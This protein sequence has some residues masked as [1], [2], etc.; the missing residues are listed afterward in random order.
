MPAVLRPRPTPDT[1]CSK[2]ALLV[3]CYMSHF[4]SQVTFVVTGRISCHKSL[5]RGV[6]HCQSSRKNAHGNVLSSIA[7]PA[8][9]LLCL[10]G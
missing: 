10:T 7:V 3:C 4:L 1:L 6:L 8:D 9:C 5:V 2:R